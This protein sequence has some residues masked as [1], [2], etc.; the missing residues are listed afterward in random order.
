MSPALASLGEDLLTAQS[1]A[2]T[3]PSLFAAT[4]K[5]VVVVVDAG[6]LYDPFVRALE[7]GGLPVFR[8]ADEAV[9]A[10]GAWL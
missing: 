1:L 10:L 2:R 3:L 7:A 4:K 5:P 6:R 8:A 9:R